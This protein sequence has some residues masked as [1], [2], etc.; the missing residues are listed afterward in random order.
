ATTDAK[1]GE[2]TGCIGCHEPMAEAP[3]ATEAAPRAALRAPSDI[4][5]PPWGVRPMSYSQLVQP[6]LDRHC[7]RCHD[8]SKGT[9]KSF[10]LTARHTKPFMNMAIPLSYHHLRRYVRHAP[11]HAYFKPPLSFGSRVSPLM[12]AL[13]KG[14]F[15][16]K[17]SPAEWRVLCAW[18]DCNAPY[19]DDY[20]AVAVK[21]QG[22]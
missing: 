1:P 2:Q 6:V 22:E 13:A 19:L 4:E 8:G 16:V 14:H 18:I 21:P 11:I 10:D 7:T 20:G 3:A 15:G 9:D 17:L 5:P 12:Q